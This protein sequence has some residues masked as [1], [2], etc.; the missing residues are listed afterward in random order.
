[1]NQLLG[2]HTS[3]S[4]GVSKSV[5][6]A[7]KLGFTAMQIFTKNNNR[8]FQKKLDDKEINAFKSKL[9]KS[10]IKFVV[11]H[12]S[13]LIN[14]CATKKI[15]LEKSRK[16]FLDELE[17]CKLLGI[18]LLNFHPGAHLGSGEEEGIKRIAESLNIAHEKTKDY[19]VSS[20][21]ETTAGQ[22]TTI[23]YR[24]E[25]LR[26]IIDRV[27]MKERMTVCIDTAHVFA[28]GYDIKDPKSF[29]EI[30]KEFDDIIGLEKLKCFHMN[31]SKK[32]LGSRVDRHE[33]IGK[34]FIGLE[35]FKN[36]MDDERLARIPK[37]LETPK[38]KE[39][40]EDLENLKVLKSL[41]KNY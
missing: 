19:N 2:A 4:G 41:I 10:N 8:W 14:L 37:I 21:L 40:L 34:G 33:H 17:R 16:A 29:N 13:Y 27:E 38:G 28:A 39:Q 30:I 24:F 23:G 25:Q 7:E 3:I 32:P 22:G 5:E 15:I 6:L 18:T 26:E 11:A 31:D 20:M 36:I 9:D 35:G 12:D 1:M